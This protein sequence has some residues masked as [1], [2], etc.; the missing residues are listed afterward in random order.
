MVDSCCRDDFDFYLIA[1]LIVRGT[2]G[3]GYHKRHRRKYVQWGL[4][5]AEISL[6]SSQSE[7]PA[8]L[9]NIIDC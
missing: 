2:G 5:C 3:D 8:S 4:M 1:S 7:N 6:A 9:I